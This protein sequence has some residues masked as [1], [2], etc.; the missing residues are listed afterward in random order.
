MLNWFIGGIETLEVGKKNN[1]YGTFCIV[2]T[3]VLGK[4]PPGLSVYLVW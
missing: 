1:N 2:R 3:S 4:L